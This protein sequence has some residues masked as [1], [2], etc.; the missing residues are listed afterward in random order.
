MDLQLKILTPLHIGNGE[1]LHSLDYIIHK[2]RFYRI[3]ANIFQRFLKTGYDRKTA[4]DY[5]S[6]FSDWTVDLANEMESLKQKSKASKNKNHRDDY[7]SQL[8]DLKKQFNYK[9][10]INSIDQRKEF[11][12]FV[13][14]ELPAAEILGGNHT[15][16][17]VR[18]MIR[19]GTDKP[20]IPGSSL[21]GAIRTAL[22]YHILE[23]HLQ[24]ADVT[25]QLNR[26]I[27][28]LK[29]KINN[30]KY[31]ERRKTLRNMAGRFGE[32][33][34]HDAFYCGRTDRDGKVIY[35]DEQM[36]LM[37]LLLVSD[38]YPENNHTTVENIDSYLVTKVKSG[39]KSSKTEIVAVKQP[40][41]PSVEAIKEGQKISGVHLKFNIEFLY[42]LKN[43]VG[44][45][46]A[47]VDREHE[48][49]YIGIKEKVK[50][51]FDLDMDS[52]EKQNEED[53]QDFFAKK[54]KEV[55]R[56]VLKCV[57]FFGQ[58][59]LMHTRQWTQNFIAHDKNKQFQKD[60]NNGF[61][62]L[63][64]HEENTLLNLGYASGFEATT[65]FFYFLEKQKPQLKEIMEL[66]S[67]G[68]NPQAHK[69][70][71]SGETYK[72]N[73]DNF[74][75]SRRLSSR[76]NEITPLGW[77]SIESTDGDA[78]EEDI[79][80]FT[81]APPPAP[82]TPDFLRGKL[83]PGVILD[84]EILQTGKPNV[85][86]LFITEDDLQEVKITYGRGFDREQIG[87]IIRVT[88]GNV[89]KKKQVLSVSF[90]NFKKQKP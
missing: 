38:A 74:P 28:N 79:E 42:N 35:S 16:Q 13:T 88:V 3:D 17:Q 85:I 53:L 10:F 78:V 52:L 57:R 23:N 72:A 30:T 81:V 18:G 36:D 45:Q 70:R 33:L 77:L 24:I 68:D 67:I 29:E 54:E 62:A 40:Q 21:K 41:A 76:K 26:R 75:K 83:R 63:E 71:R 22:F 60:L 25:K 82:V 65:G 6:R 50:Q 84:A 11:I 34:K 15:K 44:M 87:D 5:V 61:S 46:N 2:G 51:I 66:F 31:R 56:H 14:R 59:Q 55:L 8:R 43:R 49:V 19:T 32:K 86:K 20:Y 47:G 39:F 12:N 73:P 69:N 48:R 64:D 4:A 37:K 7:N 89:N 58:K 27:E 9:T 80:G 90:K 1:N